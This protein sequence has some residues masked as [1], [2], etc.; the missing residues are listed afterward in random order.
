MRDRIDRKYLVLAEQ[1]ITLSTFGKQN[2][3]P[4]TLNKKP[5]YSKQSTNFKPNH[6]YKNG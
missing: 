5:I 2:I 6:G 4:P 3:V 1:K